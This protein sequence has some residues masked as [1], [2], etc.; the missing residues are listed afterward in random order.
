VPRGPRAPGKVPWGSTA[1]L[2]MARLAVIGALALD[3]MVACMSIA[4]AAGTAVFLT[5]AEQAGSQRDSGR[6]RCGIRP[7]R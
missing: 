5:F 6:R 2:S 7:A 1:P 3:G 4:A